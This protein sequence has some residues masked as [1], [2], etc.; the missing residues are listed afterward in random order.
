MDQTLGRP[1]SYRELVRRRSAL[2]ISR[3]PS[4]LVVP[5]VAGD[6][7]AADLFLAAGDGTTRDYS[8]GCSSDGLGHCG[9]GPAFG[10]WAAT[11]LL[12]AEYVRRVCA[13][14]RDDF[15]ACAEFST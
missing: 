15:R 11:G 3:Q 5:L 9:V 4:R 6:F 7:A 8:P 12:R 1:L 14:G 10:Y 2:A 13:L